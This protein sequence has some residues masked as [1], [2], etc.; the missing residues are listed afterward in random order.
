MY[1]QTVTYGLFAARA[2]NPGQADFSRQRA[3][4]DLPRTNP[5]LRA[6]FDHVAGPNLDSKI[7]WL[8]EELAEVIGTADFSEILRDFGRRTRQEDPVV[9]FYETF[10]AAYDPALR[11][12]RGVYY[13]PEPVVS[14]IVR[15]VHH[16]LRE[17]FHKTR[18]LAEEDV[19]ILD[20]ACGTG[21]FLFFV[22]R[23]IHE[24]LQ[25]RGQGGTFSAYVARHLL[26][27]VFGFELL[28]PPYAVSHMKL[29]IELKDLGYTFETDE[30]LGI[31]LTNTLEEA[32]RQSENLWA[33][34]IT[35]E[36]NAAAE[37]K[38]DRP[39]MVVLGNPPWAGHSAN[40]SWRWVEQNGRRR[41]QTTWVGRQLEPYFEVDGQPLGERNPKWLQDD[42]VKFIRFGQW[43]IERTGEGILA[44]VTNHAYLDNPTFRGMRQNLMETFDDIYVLDLHGNYRKKET[45]PDGS[46]DE[47]VFD[48]QQGVAIGVFVKDGSRQ[49]RPAAVHHADLWGLRESK[50][51][52]LFEQ[53]LPTTAWTDLEPESPFYLFVPWN[54]SRWAEYAEGWKVTDAFPVNSVGIVTSRDA[55]VFD[56]DGEDL[57]RRIAAFADC[58]TEEARRRWDLRDKQGWHVADAQVA[59]RS[60]EHWRET[61]TP[62]LYRPFDGRWLC[63]HE[64]LIE[65]SRREVM[66]HMLAGRNL[67]ISSTRSTEIQGP[68]QH[69]FCTRLPTQHHTVSLKEVNYLFPVYLYPKDEDEPGTQ[70]EI[71]TSPWPAGPDGR[72]PNLDPA[73][74]KAFAKRLGME[75]TPDGTGDLES[76]FGP[77]DVFHYAYAV[78]HA[79]AFRERYE[80]FLRI[81]FPRLPLTSDGD[82]FRTLC[83]LGA[84]LATL[85]LMESPALENFITT[86]P[87]DGDHLVAK[88]HPRYMT[89][90]E[91]ARHTDGES[92][93]GRVYINRD[94]YFEGVP[95]E[96]WELQIGGYQVCQKWLKDRRGRTLT[97]ED[98]NHYQK[99]VVAL[100]ETIRLMGE[101]DAAI[102]SWPIE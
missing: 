95:P 70:R 37:I 86:Y 23:R 22:I 97:L 40:A 12:K 25:R 60:D 32:V 64:A 87:V 36:A 46:R 18:A 74:V 55:F 71:E 43:R 20:P 54:T 47:N 7:A 58:P 29:G 51:A 39:I 50:Q 90:Q 102:P 78:F 11:E 24:E 101:I 41:K 30:R 48:I 91:V 10:L 45:C 92:E 62:C 67:A 72:R 31:Y 56:F 80:E 57:E 100:S 63:Y 61:L 16:L 3:V 4:F 49:G 68:F 82:L 83:G 8:V 79:P 13:T 81:D 69:V 73:F 5:F 99:I 84:E 53:E 85:H 19:F 98:I 94:Q 96:V 33:R 26:P 27:R 1:A 44:F 89:P 9:H 75:F 88:G 35:E 76:T 65:R 14:Y 38:R 59:V 52:A 21:T 6:L 77:E 28:M 93:A 2:Q 17:R 15:S 66:Q 34:W 42:Y